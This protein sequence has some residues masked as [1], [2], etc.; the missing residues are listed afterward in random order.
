MIPVARVDFLYSSMPDVDGDIASPVAGVTWHHQQLQQSLA[1]AGEQAPTHV[2]FV[3][4]WAKLRI[5]MWERI[6]SVRFRADSGTSATT[7]DLW[8]Q[9]VARCLANSVTNSMAIPESSASKP[10]ATFLQPAN[11]ESLSAFLASMPGKAP[12]FGPLLKHKYLRPWISELMGSEL[13]GAT[14]VRSADLRSALAWM[15][16]TCFLADSTS[17][18]VTIPAMRWQSWLQVC[19][20]AVRTS[21]DKYPDELSRIMTP[22]AAED[23]VDGLV[24]LRP[25]YVV[26]MV[27]NIAK[28]VLSDTETQLETWMDVE[29]RLLVLS[30]VIADPQPNLLTKNDMKCTS[31]ESWVSYWLELLTFTPVERAQLQR[32]LKSQEAHRR[33]LVACVSDAATPQA[34]GSGAS[35]AQSSEA[36]VLAPTPQRTGT[37][38]DVTDAATEMA[39]ILKA[40]VTFNAMYTHNYD[41]TLDVV[42]AL[43]LENVERAVS[44]FLMAQV[45]KA[46]KFDQLYVRFDESETVYVSTSG[47]GVVPFSGE[48]VIDS[49]TDGKDWSVIGT[50]GSHLKIHLKPGD[51]SRVASRAPIVPWIALAQQNKKP[52]KDI[53]A[54]TSITRPNCTIVAVED[55]IH[56]DQYGMLCDSPPPPPTSVSSATSTEQSPSAA[57]SPPIK[58]PRKGGQAKAKATPNT[59]ASPKHKAKPEPLTSPTPSRTAVLTIKINVPALV[60]AEGD[61][62]DAA[63]LKDEPIYISPSWKADLSKSM[64]LVEAVVVSTEVPATTVETEA[65]EGDAQPAAA[66]VVAKAKPKAK[67]KAK[68]KP[69]ASA[70]AAENAAAGPG[71]QFGP[72][73]LALK[74]RKTVKDQQE[75]TSAVA[76]PTHAPQ[77][78]PTSYHGVSVKHIIG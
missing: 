1:T 25:R 37:V 46:G 78:I 65:T 74:M 26:H 47:V 70:P 24:K 48:C 28:L 75:A 41:L 36:V 29:Q 51:H 62:K 32:V 57:K 69:T 76:V 60:F 23:I 52:L 8:A 38:A 77:A 14:E 45:M 49:A 30:E 20:Y 33:E 3:K 10:V 50:I 55:E 35:G 22:E 71:L 61:H 4:F 42:P 44:S 64:G 72:S 73:A 59:K 54:A 39:A 11:L 13:S 7:A 19:S 56:V 12:N 68:A 34:A 66:K 5:L 27:G 31:K 21:P 18:N 15:A 43:F 40:G 6:E 2:E 58:K 63:N 53:L 67:H 9:N 17:T 16:G